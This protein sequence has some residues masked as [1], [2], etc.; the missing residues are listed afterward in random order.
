MPL[1]TFDVVLSPLFELLARNPAGLRRGE[2]VERLANE[3][4]LT[5]EERN[6]T[7]GGTGKLAFMNI[8][9][10]AHGRLKWAGLSSAP[11]RGRWQLTAEGMTRHAV[12]E[13]PGRREQRPDRASCMMVVLWAPARTGSISADPVGLI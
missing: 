12:R 5:E 11:S 1:P 2:A 10:W 7:L 3:F 8:V 4:S 9:D 6:A 13:R